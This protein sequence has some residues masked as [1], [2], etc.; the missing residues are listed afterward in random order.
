VYAPAGVPPDNVVVDHDT[1]TSRPLA[2][3]TGAPACGIDCNVARPKPAPF[4]EN[5]AD[6]NLIG[7]ATKAAA[8]NTVATA[9]RPTRGRVRTENPTASN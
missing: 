1:V 9:A 3:A 5:A 6:A 7:N 8:A 2:T 4:A